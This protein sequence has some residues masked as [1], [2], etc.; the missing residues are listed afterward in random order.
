M[1]CDEFRHLMSSAAGD[2]SELEKHLC[3]CQACDS[4]LKGELASPPSG[5]TP[6]QWHNATARCFPE[7]LPT[8]AEIQSE[9]GFWHFFFNGLKYGVVFGLA[10][11]TGLAIV[12]GLRTPDDA[13]KPGD[14]E[15]VSFVADAYPEAVELEENFYTDV[16]FY[17]TGESKSVSFLPQVQMPDFYE[18][19]DHTEEEET[20]NENS[21]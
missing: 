1:Q 6:A 14:F 13:V 2:E 12:D 4:W 21:G 10:L 11:I 17:E 8:G 16:T 3:G 20:W 7:N 19:D 5:L 18:T 15:L 9:P